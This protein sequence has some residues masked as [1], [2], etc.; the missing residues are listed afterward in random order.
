MYCLQ[1]LVA[2]CI[3]NYFHLRIGYVYSRV[4]PIDASVASA[5]AIVEGEPHCSRGVH[6]PDDVIAQ[7]TLELCHA[8][9]GQGK[10]GAPAKV[11]LAV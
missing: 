3:K 11:D 9:V 4:I 10:E 1:Y 7:L 6:V 5:D 2:N 8:S